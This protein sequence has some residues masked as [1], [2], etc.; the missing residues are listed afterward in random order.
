MYFTAIKCREKVT[1]HKAI[2]LLESEPWREG[3]WDSAAMAKIA[4]RRIVELEDD[5]WYDTEYHGT[6]VE[7]TGRSAELSVDWPLATDPFIT[8]PV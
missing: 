4:R 8:Y 1:A 6:P 3:A 2:D 5:G 7:D